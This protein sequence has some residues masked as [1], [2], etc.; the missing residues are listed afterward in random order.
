MNIMI[1][2][3]LI[4]I[5]FII[6]I[7]FIKINIIDGSN[8]PKEKFDQRIDGA[9]KEQCGIMCT[10]ILGCKGF[11]H[12][13]ENKY[14]FVSKD[15]IIINPDKK[16]YSQF[17]KKSFPRCNKLYKIDDPYYNSRNNIIRNATYNCQNVENAKFEPT[18]YDNKEKKNINIK[19]LNL[20]EIAPYTFVDIE[21]S[22][23]VPISD[24]RFNTDLQVPVP[25]EKNNI[26]NDTEHGLYFGSS[27]KI[28]V[29][30]DQNNDNI[31]SGTKP[32]LQDKKVTP[33]SSGSGSINLDT[34]LHL[35]TNPT[36]SNSID[37]MREYNQEF[38]GQYMFPHKCSTNIS[39]DDCMKQ[40]LD[41][42][43]CVG[44]EWNPIL[45]KKVGKPNK[46]KY[47]ENVCCPKIKLKKVMPRRK[48]AR[49]GH[50]YLKEKA[51]RQYIQKGEILVGL[52]KDKESDGISE[53]DGIY[54]KWK[55]NIY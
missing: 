1:D 52:N 47:D 32:I 31:F 36:E 41:N 12:D 9:S 46:Y 5:I 3:N 8:K 23:S 10:K 27:R 4:F 49:F 38:T 37:I 16:A 39:K 21:W 17:Y 35:I 53:M 30:P 54:A 19:N 11:A 29:N 15:D 6:I 14:C 2:P 51:N 48:E 44:T 42:K 45:F 20:E 55:N 13:A 18:I 28:I 34:N 50:F 7:Y 33:L 40:C 43:D 25:G 22:G 26:E 24:G